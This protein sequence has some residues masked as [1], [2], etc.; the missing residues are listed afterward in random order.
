MMLYLGLREAAIIGGVSCKSERYHHHDHSQPPPRAHALATH[1]YCW[2]E[3]W[4]RLCIQHSSYS[5]PRSRPS[6]HM[7]V[8]PLMQVGQ[9]LP[10][11]KSTSVP[12]GAGRVPLSDRLRRLDV[13]RQSIATKVRSAVNPGMHCVMPPLLTAEPSCSLH[14]G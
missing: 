14:A 8:C 7:C 1:A 3:L 11:A 12:Y 13:V 6:P 2:P 4:Y 10:G 9:S 5:V